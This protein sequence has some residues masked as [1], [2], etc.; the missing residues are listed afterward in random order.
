MNRPTIASDST[1]ANNKLLSA[2]LFARDM[3]LQGG[4][5]NI[6][7]LRVHIVKL[8]RALSVDLCRK[9]VTNARVRLQEAVRQN[10]GHNEHVLHYEQF[11]SL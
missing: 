8:C 3:I 4:A 10:G 7:Q 11:S 1:R 2:Y 9:V 6:A 5:R